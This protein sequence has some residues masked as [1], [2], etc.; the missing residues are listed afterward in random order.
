VK[1]RRATRPKR[2]YAA[3]CQRCQYPHQSTLGRQAIASPHHALDLPPVVHSPV[4]LPP[5]RLLRIPD[6]VR[7]SD[8]MVMADLAPAHPAEKFLGVVRV[9]QH[10]ATV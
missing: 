10:P 4:I 1:L 2:R 5:R 9:R 8:A 3:F 7:A 6:Q